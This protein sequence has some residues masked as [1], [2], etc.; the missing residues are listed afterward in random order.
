MG[1]GSYTAAD[2][3]KLK[4]SRAIS[5]SSSVE[6]IF[7][8]KSLKDVY[9]PAFINMRESCDSEDSPEST[10]I[11]LAFDD[12]GSMGYLA[13]EIAVNALNKTITDLYEKQPIT[14]PHIMC[15]TFGNYG[16]QA[17]LQVTQYEADIRVVEQLLD[18]WIEGRGHGYSGDTFVWYFAAK[19]T[20]IDCFDKRKKKGFLFTIGDDFCSRDLMMNETKSIFDDI[21]H[22]IYTPEQL[23]CMAS[24][25]YEI[26][27]ILVKECK[28]GYYEKWKELL[29][30]RVASIDNVKY[31]S[32][33]IS[34]II[35]IASG[36]D[37]ET[38]IEQAGEDAP[39]FR[40]ALQDINIK[41]KKP[42]S[43]SS[44]FDMFKR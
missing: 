8:T 18:L 33:V 39:Y 43:W 5:D 37:K 26:F 30:G 19:H 12:T 4:A 32:D 23:I 14:N 15:A 10:P 11:I 22:N 25:K 2:W 1:Q 17:P 24:E 6:A 40:V 42:L 29:P 20:K 27:H 35:R 28:K 13:K 38:V 44:L 31:L 21:V 3:T 9:N 41:H 36:E 34:S 7:K 16:D